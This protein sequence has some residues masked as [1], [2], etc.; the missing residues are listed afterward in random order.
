MSER[1]HATSIDKAN[2]NRIGPPEP[3]GRYE[4]FVQ[5][6]ESNQAVNMHAQAMFNNWKASAVK[7][8]IWQDTKHDRR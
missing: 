4:K 7:V 3:K 5:K 1:D 8:R 6:Y 2:T